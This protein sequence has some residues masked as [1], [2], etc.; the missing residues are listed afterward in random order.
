MKSRL[1]LL[2]LCV[3][4]LVQA[5]EDNSVQQ[6]IQNTAEV[7]TS[8]N[9]K[10]TIGGYGEAHFNQILNKDTRYNSILDVHRLVM[11]LGYNFSSKTQ[12]ISE[13]EFEHVSEVYVEQMYM[14]QKLNKYI[15]LQAGLLLV[16]MGII[17]LYH[18]PTTFNGVERPLIDNKLTPTT[19][20]E[21]GFGAQGNITEAMLKYQVYLMNGFSGYDG[22]AA[23]FSGSKGFRSGRQKGA[24]SYMSS[25]NIAG[26]VQYYGISGLN[27]GLSA[28]SGNSQSK[29]YNN[30]DV[31]NATAVAKA[32]SS[33][34]GINML[35]LDYIYQ[36]KAFESRA[37]LYY[38]SLSNTDQYNFFTR[39]SGVKNDL[40][41]SMIG[42]YV[43]AGYDVMSLCEK[44]NI[45]L[46]PFVRY[47]AYNSHLTVDENAT[48][49]TKY[50][51]NSITTGLTLKLNK[52]AVV[53]A[54]LDFAKTEF[55]TKYTTTL[56]LG[57]GV[58]F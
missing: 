5:Q 25:P 39:K 4:I 49:N 41:K 51:G 1:L 34:V 35:G 30:L 18:E 14:Q 54:D 45:G 57:V 43:E 10:L 23:I 2:L 31:N 21:I 37:Q 28:Y 50:A 26:R 15:N 55:D 16:P 48:A 6:D 19:W 29:L 53:K 17:N 52:G 11:F 47:Q 44:S 33:V 42:Y 7:L 20:R 8:S 13:I 46:V 24:E 3:T 40:G 22:T 56:N 38:T 36:K 32:D 27:L 9:D 12:F 58:M